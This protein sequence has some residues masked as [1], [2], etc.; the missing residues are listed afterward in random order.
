[1]IFENF[2][3]HT[4][5]DVRKDP[6]T[7]NKQIVIFMDNATIHK[8]PIIYKTARKMKAS[9]MLNASYSPWLIQLSSYSIT[10]SESF[11][12]KILCHQSKCT[13]LG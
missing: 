3:Y 9:I 1:M 11:A 2:I 8:V 5:F 12:A 6:L 10:L 13:L 7:A 4:L